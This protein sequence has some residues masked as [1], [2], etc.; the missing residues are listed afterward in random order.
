MENLAGAKEDLDE[1][2]EFLEEKYTVFPI[3]N[4][5]DIQKEITTVMEALPDSCKPVTHLQVVYSGEAKTC[6]ERYNLYLLQATVAT[7]TRWRRD[8][9]PQ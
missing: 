9:S 2:T 1:L 3:E 4:A 5:E 8:L 6:P 7:G